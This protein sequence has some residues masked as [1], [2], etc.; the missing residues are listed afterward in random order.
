MMATKYMYYS[1]LFFI[2]LIMVFVIT[3]SLASVQVIKNQ[4]SLPSNHAAESFTF[5][6][7]TYNFTYVASNLS[8]QEAGLMNKTVTN[9]TFELFAFPQ[10]SIYPFWMKNTYYPLD[11][12]WIN[13]STVTYIANATPCS[14]YD[15]NQSD[16]IIY[17]PYNA[18]HMANYVIEAL[19]G[20]TNRTGLKVGDKVVIK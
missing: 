12:I 16:C 2:F 10:P 6:N 17:N 11:I 19:S 3:I 7:M 5:G 18:G 20:F 1:A 4:S 9:S 13:G 14:F 15:K 8:E